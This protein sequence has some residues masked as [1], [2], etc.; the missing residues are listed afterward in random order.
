MT[1]A[2]AIVALAAVGFQGNLN[3][4][5]EDSGKPAKP[6][7]EDRAGLPLQSI[8]GPG[9]PPAPGPQLY[10]FLEQLPPYYPAALFPE[11]LATPGKP[12]D[13]V[14]D[15]TKMVQAATARVNAE[16][17]QLTRD[18]VIAVLR[19]AGW[20]ESAIPDA[21]A[22]SW[23]ESKWS[24]YAHNGGN[25]GLF[26]LNVTDGATT[27]GS[28]FAYWGLP[29]DGWSDPVTNATAARL[30]YEYSLARNGYGWSPWSC[31]PS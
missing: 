22:V 20:P 12:I 25:A 28:W 6:L 3:P 2:T 5:G 18:E 31:K 16:G 23:C 7:I 10:E 24:P 9:V 19:A 11:R 1:C 4:L 8:D 14:P 26:Q 15:A 17:G 27:R 21:L 30:T 29:E 13:L